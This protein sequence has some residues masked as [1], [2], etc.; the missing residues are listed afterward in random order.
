MAHSAEGGSNQDVTGTYLPPR[1][2]GY[3]VR[4]C[5]GIG[6]SAAVWL[7]ANTGTGTERALKILVG[8]PAQKDGDAQYEIR[9]EMAIL[10]RH[11]HPHLIAIHQFLDTDQ[12][13]ALLM[14]YAAGGSVG[15]LVAAR[16][17]LPV[18][19]VIT[20]LTPIAQ[21]LSYLHENGVTHGDVSPGNVLFTSE[22]MP[23]LSDLGVSRLLGEAAREDHGTPGFMPV[24]I[25]GQGRAQPE[26]DVYALGAL[27]WYSLTGRVPAATASRPP[28]SVLV[29]GVPT[30][31][32]T[33]IESALSENAANRPS[34]SEFSRLIYNCADALPMD[35]VPSAHITVLP[36]L[37]TRRSVQ[38]QAVKKR[39]FGKPV[40]KRTRSAASARRRTWGISAAAAVLVVGGVITGIVITSNPAGSSLVS[41]ATKEPT[42]QAG[43][44]A[45]K[46]HAKDDT[47]ERSGREQ[48]VEETRSRNP[49]EALAALA[50]LRAE[51]YQSGD[52]AVLSL[53]NA[54]GSAAMKADLPRVSALASNGRTM[55]GLSFSLEHVVVQPGSSPEATHVEAS[56][57]TSGF[58]EKDASG[59]TIRQEKAESTQHFVFTLKKT[60]DGW[61]ITDVTKPATDT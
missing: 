43:D 53:V 46:S 39:L 49:A 31:L 56:V 15:Q 21:A 14:D 36:E 32:V 42:T 50:Q 23:L 38:Q 1:L 13:P 18:G 9:R 3:E 30:E 28:L 8:N 60:A 17:P 4:R 19:E 24:R 34:A 7:V 26:A 40:K 12:G 35:L 44:S 2:E 45:D 61:R 48:L 27:A 29:P 58:T 47:G 16:G 20:L 11:S 55:S 51:A 57:R 33:V 22:G 41:S 25:N 5:L 37:K 54:E 59:A 10:S 6:G 52:P